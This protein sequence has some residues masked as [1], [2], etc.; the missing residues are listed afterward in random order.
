MLV[1]NSVTGKEQEVIT[2]SE[3]KA[4]GLKKYFTGKPCKYG[5]V[6]E[7]QVNGGCIECSR[8]RMAKRKEEG[9]VVKKKQKKSNRSVMIKVL[10]SASTRA[11][12]YLVMEGLYDEG[13]FKYHIESLFEDGMT[14]ENHGEYWEVDHIT[15]I[16]EMIKNG[17]TDIMKI[18][19]LSNLRPL[20]KEVHRT[21]S[22][23]LR[24]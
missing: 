3:A 13:E 10:N 22:G 19:S 9:L 16:R 11:S 1:L 21:L 20:K 5:H 23:R 8:L 12:S 14:W 7:K 18:N 2:F 17:V 6:D 24:S 4:S 15:P